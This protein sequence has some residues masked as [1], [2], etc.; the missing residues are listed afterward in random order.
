MKELREI[1]SQVFRIGLSQNRD[2]V[3]KLLVFCTNPES[4]NYHYA[5][6][7]FGYTEEP[8]LFLYNLM[9]R[10]S[11][12]MGN[13]RRCV[14][15]FVRLREDGLSPDNFTFPFVLKA[16]GCSKMV[17]EGKK[18]HGLIVKTGFE[19]VS[20]VRNSLMD[21]YTEMGDV[22]TLRFLFDEN[23]ERDLV[24]WNVLI[25]GYVRCGKFEDALVIY[26]KM[27]EESGFKPDEATLVST[28]SACAALRNLELGKEIQLYI[29]SEHEFTILLSNALLGMYSKCGCLVQA[30]Q[31]FDEMPVKNVITWTSI[32]SGYVN[33][34][35]IDEAR[36]LFKRSPVR[37]VVLWTA[38]INGYVQ[39][40]QIDE[41]LSLFNEMQTKGLKPDGFTAVALLTGCAQ[42]GALE[43]G[44]WIHAYIEDHN[45]RMDA[46]V[47]TALID[48]YAK[49]GFIE[50]S[51]EIF[52]KVD[53]RDRSIWTA[54]ICGLALNG[55]TNKALELF[56][57]MKLSAVKPDDIT[58]IGVLSA[59]NHAHM[60][61]EGRSYFESMKTIYQIEPKLEHYGCLVD[62]LGR[63]GKISEVEDIVEKIPNIDNVDDLL[64][65]WGSLLGACKIHGNVETSERIAKRLSAKESNNSGIL[66]LL[67]NI[68][69]AAERW[70][71]VNRVRRK[72]KSLGVQK[73]PGCSSIELNGVVH[74]FLVG[75]S[76]HPEISNIYSLLND[77]SRVMFSS[78]EN[79]RSIKT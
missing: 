45:I 65:L 23:P 76:S 50:K 37:D 36:E 51:M 43:Q 73:L 68:Y 41:A 69:A 47:G 52:L 9:I 33:S 5:E 24:C 34:G 67:A 74:E 8:T 13:L 11:T 78:E 17:L 6:R 77:M 4:G 57:E 39:F 66:T 20:F 7:V 53:E 64:P 16:I 40:N 46:V 55:Q 72:M 31:V 59:C 29:R 56:S 32:V 75:G 62:L 21:M 48:M 18:I 79:L 58:F 10:A 71:D 49:C 1:Q 2:A 63:A 15:L 70:E 27:R 28:L 26:R 22:E 38:M 19:F 35:L 3:N 61:D 30:R 14:S 54:I 12:K 25:S 42:L 60:V 44:R